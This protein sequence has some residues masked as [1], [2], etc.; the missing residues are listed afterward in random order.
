MKI[1]I[2]VVTFILICHDEISKYV[3]IIGLIR[4]R[5]NM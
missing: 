2:T 3:Y 1:L 4:Y 5:R